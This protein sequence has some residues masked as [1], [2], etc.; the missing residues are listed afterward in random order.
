MSTTVKSVGC[1][2]L[3][4]G[5]FGP[6]ACDDEERAVNIASSPVTLAFSPL[7]TQ[8]QREH[9]VPAGLHK[10]IM[11][12]RRSMCTSY[13]A[14]P[15]CHGAHSIYARL[16]ESGDERARGIY[17]SVDETL[18]RLINVFKYQIMDFH[19]QMWKIQRAR[20]KSFQLELGAKAAEDEAEKL[21]RRDLIYPEVL[22]PQLLSS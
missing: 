2:G 4:K 15:Q 17:T 13:E 5:V 7:L 11:A 12:T 1:S 6:L 20:I 14:I 3:R 18:V 8:S 22:M 19:G 10:G 9:I 21:V 16:A